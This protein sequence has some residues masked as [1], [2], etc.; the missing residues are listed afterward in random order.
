VV[1]IS[2]S[3]NTQNRFKLFLPQ[4]HTLCRKT[5]LD[6]IAWEAM[7]KV[8][9]IPGLFLDAIGTLLNCNL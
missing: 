2:R 6:Q 7:V 4:F 3:E 8:M 5:Y 1:A 9:S